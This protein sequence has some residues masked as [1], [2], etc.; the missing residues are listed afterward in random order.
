MNGRTAI[1]LKKTCGQV[2][3]GP[4]WLRIKWEAGQFP[5]P[6][7]LEPN[8]KLMFWQDEIDTWL[9]ARAKRVDIEAAAA[10]RKGAKAEGSAE[11]RV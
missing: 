10:R 5:L 1:P 11:N 8:G 3:Y 2:G 7:Q 6:F 9:Q 4:T